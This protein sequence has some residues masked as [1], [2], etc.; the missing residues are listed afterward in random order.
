[1]KGSA[2][3]AIVAVIAVIAVAGAAFALMSGGGSD[4]GSETYTVTF[5][6]TGGS[7]VPSQSVASGGKAVEPSA[8]VRPGYDFAGWYTSATGG[9]Q[10]GFGTKIS[11]DTALYARWNQH[12]D[13]TFTVNFNANGGTPSTAQAVSSGSYASAPADPAWSGYRF[14]ALSRI[15]FP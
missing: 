15:F 9:S 8:P 1:M 12:P 10:F 7:Y 11:K 14:E 13:V 6:S 3:A 4:N 5:D 2:I